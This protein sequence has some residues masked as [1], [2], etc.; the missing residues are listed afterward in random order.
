LIRCCGALI[1]V[2]DSDGT[3][4]GLRHPTGIV[5]ALGGG[6]VDDQAAVAATGIRMADVP[7]RCGGE[8]WEGVPGGEPGEVV[9]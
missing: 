6:G 3:A 9:G 8:D 5:Q 1:G 2:A 7:V 4:V